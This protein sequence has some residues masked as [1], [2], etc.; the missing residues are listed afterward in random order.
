MLG[1]RQ[2]AEPPPGVARALEHD[3]QAISPSEAAED[4]SVLEE[5]LRKDPDNRKV[6]KRLA[7]LL[8]ER[9][10][11][12]TRAVPLLARIV[13]DAP[14]SAGWHYYLARALRESGRVEEAA[15]H[16][17]AV[18]RLQPENRWA[19]YE[20]G[21]TLSGTGRFSEAEEAYRCALGDRE[22]EGRVRVAL[23]KVL[24]ASGR[25]AEA[26]MIA[27][28]VLA[29]DPGDSEAAQLASAARQRE[30]SE[31]AAHGNQRVPGW[32][33]VRA[34][35][36][37]DRAV[38]EA[39]RLKTRAAFQR[40]CSVLE[41]VLKRF[42]ND[43]VKRKALASIYLE[44]L[45]AP[46]DAVP[47][48]RLIVGKAPKAGAWWQMLA[49]AQA[50]TGDGKGAVESYRSAVLYSPKDVWLF[51]KLGRAQR[52]LG[53]TVEAERS[54]AEALAIEPGNVYVRR[55]LARCH[56]DLGRARQ[57]EAVARGLVLE[58]PRDGE[59]RVVLGDVARLKLN[60]SVAKEEYNEAL[61]SREAYPLANAGLQEINRLKRPVVG[62]V[63][64]SFKDTDGFTQSG[65]FNHLSLPVTERLKSSLVL[66]DRYFSKEGQPEFRRLE[67]SVGADYWLL[68]EWKIA[69]AGNVFEVE[70]RGARG[71]GTAAV[72]YNPSKHIGLWTMQRVSEPVND[73]Y[74]AARDVLRQS[75][76]S[77]GVNLHASKEVLFS[78]TGSRGDYSDGNVRKAFLGG[79]HW[80]APVY[81]APVARMELEAIEYAFSSPG[82]SS[83]RSYKRVRPG[84]DW[85]PRL[86]DWL[87]L[88][89]H[90]ELSYVCGIGD[91]GTGFSAGLRFNKG[92]TL[93]FGGGF[94]KY[95]IPG[96][97]STWSGRGVKAD[98]TWRF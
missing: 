9:L 81:G 80:Y 8:F 35:D 97:Q 58:N 30:G 12:A 2:D 98:L 17:S 64:Y 16:F 77:A 43:L 42:P 68:P 22:T 49:T 44:K 5:Y 59:A 29:R 85:G 53:R 56:Y 15:E 66:N 75:V 37:A 25:P 21:N 23:A 6:R 71:G 38:V 54:F 10:G 89:L 86:T 76:L 92:E 24:W 87:R 51:Y 82:Y 45:H 13:E 1:I 26:A 91:W 61:Y 50:E 36:E 4:V 62:S 67:A 57:A 60:F 46:A 88:D 27:Q 3:Y 69:G 18:V 47:H 41:R 95:E 84:V 83:P 70:N 73:S 40:A 72:Y 28:T 34:V 31:A 20:L 74:A 93:D 48:L 96:G 7:L 19:F 11:E 39:Y 63:Y 33:G 14:E 94:M 90:G 79:V 32:I 52:S 78:A 55:E 65:L